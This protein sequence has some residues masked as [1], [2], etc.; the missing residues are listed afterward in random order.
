MYLWVCYLCMATSAIFAI[1]LALPRV[2]GVQIDF[3]QEIGERHLKYKHLQTASGR[4]T[5]VPKSEKVGKYST[6]NIA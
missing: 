4:V 2:F 5:K 1:N 6:V 3:S